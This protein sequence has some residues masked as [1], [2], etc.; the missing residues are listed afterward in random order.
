MTDLIS[1][2]PRRPRPPGPRRP[3]A[4][5]QPAPADSPQAVSLAG[6]IAALRAAA[7]GLLTVMVLVLVA[8]ATAADSGASAT[9]AVGGGLAIWLV[10]HLAGLSVPAGGFGLAPLGLTGLL[11]ALLFSSGVRAA[12]AAQV[13]G[14]RA[15]G[16][17]T[18]TL[19][20]SYAAVAVVVSLLARTAA[21]QPRPV[22]AFLGAGALALVAGGAG[23]VRGSGRSAAWWSRVPT[24]AR[25]AVTGAAGAL[26]VLLSGGSLLVAAMLCLHRGEASR[27][28]SGL[29]AGT[30]GSLLVLL[31]CVLY[32]PTAVVWGASYLAGPGFAVGTG[33]SVAVTGVHL[34]AVPALP[35]LAALP[36][37]GAAGVGWPLAVAASLAAGLVSGVLVDRAARREPGAPI[38]SW[39]DLLRVAGLTG[40]VTG[41]ALGALAAASSGPAG[42]GRLAHAGPTAWWVGLAAAATTAVVVAG[43]LAGRRLELFH[44][45]AR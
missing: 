26:I 22:T 34:G 15:V 20:A 9:E 36:G 43:I 16:S 30:A 33:T 19:A 32:A 12:R 35:L 7:L 45:A 1:R 23:V 18:V 38:S 39:R 42:P 28:V 14:H 3:A 27:V 40:A 10:G 31:I 6:T 25:L 24:I 11:A 29:H 17:L 2:P 5:P 21:V 4:P 13:R 37:T 44:R 41:L 8:W